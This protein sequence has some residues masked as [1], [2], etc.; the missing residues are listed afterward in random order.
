MAECE[1]NIH[2]MAL[3]PSS[4]KYNID[5]KKVNALACL[6]H[7]ISWHENVRGSEATA[8]GL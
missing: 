6:M 3:K 5:G 4:G 2:L 7:S 8:S 1:S